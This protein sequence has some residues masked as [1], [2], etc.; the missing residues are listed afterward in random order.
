MTAMEAATWTLI[1][2]VIGGMIT[3]GVE[4]RVSY[5]SLRTEI[6][7]RFDKVDRR[8]EQVDRRFEQVDHRFEQVDHRFERLATEVSDL[9]R[10]QDRMAGTL[11]VLVQM[12]HT[13]PTAER[14]GRAGPEAPGPPAT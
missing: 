2:V 1:A 7:R 4:L 11:D 14:P 3:F 10:A 13:H 6:D 8:F 9:A 5:R 12:A